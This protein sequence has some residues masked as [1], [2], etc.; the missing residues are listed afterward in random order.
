MGAV[1]FVFGRP[2]AGGFVTRVAAIDCGTNSIRLLIADSQPG[3]TLAEVDRRMQIVRLGQDVDRTGLLGSEAL[4]RTLA[5]TREY[6]GRCDAAGVDAVRFIATS[7]TRDARNRSEFVDGVR[8]ILG[9]EPEVVDGETEAALSFSG[10]TAGLSAGHADPFLVADLGGGSTELVLGHAGRAGSAYSADIGSVRLTERHLRTDPP[11][12]AERSAASADIDAAL[13]RV[14]TVVPLDQ[15]AT[16]V[17]VAGSITTIAAHALGLPA[18]QRERIDGAVIQIDEI[19]GACED[20]LRM[21][22][23]KRAALPYLHPGRVDVIGAG[24]LIWELV[25]QRVAAASGIAM[26]VTSERDILDGIAASLL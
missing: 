3:G 2:A 23:E 12:A 26:A 1:P 6:A 13:D 19:V 16:L 8:A 17:G 20:L 11:T 10:A 5:A 9:V 14:A 25:V 18:Y 24:A 22:R 15:T 4:A 7:A 21:S